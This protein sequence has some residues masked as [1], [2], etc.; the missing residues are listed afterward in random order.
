MIT[1]TLFSL[2]FLRQ[3]MRANMKEQGLSACRELP[4]PSTVTFQD[5]SKG[6]KGLDLASLD[7]AELMDKCQLTV[8][9]TSRI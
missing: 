6:E 7:I 1:S 5:C 3:I 8:Y 4:W 9:K 2:L